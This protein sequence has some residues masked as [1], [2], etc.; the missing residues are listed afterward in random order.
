MDSYERILYGDINVS[1]KRVCTSR[2]EAVRD[3][4]GVVTHISKEVQEKEEAPG[5]QRRES[6]G[7]DGT[8][9]ASEEEVRRAK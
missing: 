4:N 9:A 5:Q 3:G 6:V 2:V 8:S 7:D 1:S